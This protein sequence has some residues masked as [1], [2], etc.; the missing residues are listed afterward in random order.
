MSVPV[1]FN[2]SPWGRFALGPVIGDHQTGYVNIGAQLQ[3]HD[4][5]NFT[6]PY[7]Y[8]IGPQAGMVNSVG[9]LTYAQSMGDRNYVSLSVYSTFGVRTH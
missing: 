7:Q 8:F 9:Q 5:N 6:V 2:Y 1:G 4:V 3:Y